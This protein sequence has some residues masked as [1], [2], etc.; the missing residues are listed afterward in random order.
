MWIKGSKKITLLV[1]GLLVLVITAA[2]FYGHYFNSRPYGYTYKNLQ[3]TQVNLPQGGT[4]S[5]NK[6]PELA[7]SASVHSIGLQDYQ[8]IKDE[9]TIAGIMINQESF[10]PPPDT[11]TPNINETFVIIPPITKLDSPLDYIRDQFNN[12]LSDAF[13]T[14]KKSLIEGLQQ[15]IAAQYNSSQKPKVELQAPVKLQTANIKTDAWQMDFTV[16]GLGSGKHTAADVIGKELFTFG[17]NNTLDNLVLSAVD[18]NWRTN[19]ATWQRI[20]D[21]IKV[22]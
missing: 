12:P 10:P 17:S 16:S 20:I 11:G 19:Q 7:K 21:S 4:L 14:K 8:H 6:P 15:K 1:V 5:F 18:Y 9:N 3:S 22:N 13:Q 2:G